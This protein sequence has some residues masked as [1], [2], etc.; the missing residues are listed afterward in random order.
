M[1]GQAT[2]VSKQHDAKNLAKLAFTENAIAN[3][4][5]FGP[6]DTPSSLFQKNARTQ[7]KKQNLRKKVDDNEAINLENQ[8]KKNCII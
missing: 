6:R 2:P 8:M 7:I 1:D 4:P 5:S 3:R